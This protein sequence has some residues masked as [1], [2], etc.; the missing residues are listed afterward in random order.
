MRR[1]GAIVV[2]LLVFVLVD[3]VLVGM[4]LRSTE[5][6]PRQRPTAAAVS[7]PPV[8]GASAPV[9]NPPSTGATTPTSTDKGH[10]SV[11]V[12]G[13]GPQR[14]WRAVTASATCSKH[15]PRVKV[16]HTDDGGKTWETVDVPMTAVSGMEY[17]AG[18]I[19]A[20]GLNG[21]CRPVRYALTSAE[22]PEVTD[23]VPTWSV[24]PKDRT[25]LET[26][27]SPASR[28]PCS[29]DVLDVAGTSPQRATVLCDGGRVA[30]TTD[31]GKSWAKLGKAPGVVALAVTATRHTVYVAQP[32]SCGLE[33]ATLT[34]SIGGK[35]ACPEG[36]R[37]THPP[38]DLSIVGGTLWLATGSD[39]TA[40][41][42][43]DAG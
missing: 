18:R 30:R 11:I 31:G 2:A 29:G 24:D 21:S 42:V 35:A 15:D 32:G 19:I 27:G 36:A 14:A 4:A 39:A 5:K 43:A 20:T 8:T 12:V 34:K 23:Q 28:Q 7:A 13:L 16:G 41:P 10:G 37:D 33:V 1:H 17:R 3:V 25:V 6:T 26:D 40:L 38:A 22:S 9:I